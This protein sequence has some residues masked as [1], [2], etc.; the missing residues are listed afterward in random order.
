MLRAQALQLVDELRVLPQLW[1]A[2]QFAPE[3]SASC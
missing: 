1:A 3:L 2:P